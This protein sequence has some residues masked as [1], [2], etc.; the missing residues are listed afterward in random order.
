M[1]AV[2]AF[3]CDFC[4]KYGKN[5]TRIRKH[6]EKCY[7]RPETQSCGS[8]GHLSD[9]SCERGVKFLHEEGKRTP[10]LRTMCPLY[11]NIDEMICGSEDDIMSN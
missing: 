5:S 3:Q 11:Q 6:E 1:K 8:C 9:W 7:Y 10:T 4:Q 2:Q